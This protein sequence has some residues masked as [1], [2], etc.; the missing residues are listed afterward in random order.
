MVTTH[1]Y[2]TIMRVKRTRWME[3]WHLFIEFGV[4]LCFYIIAMIKG[5]FAEEAITNTRCEHK[6][7]SAFNIYTEQL[8]R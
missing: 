7:D 5:Y 1:Y 3:K 4:I 8:L 6:V 2:T